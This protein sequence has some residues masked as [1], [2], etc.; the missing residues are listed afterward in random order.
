MSCWNRRRLR[1]SV[2]YADWERLLGEGTIVFVEVSGGGLCCPR[3]FQ[4]A[5][6]G[7]GFLNSSFERFELVLD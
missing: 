7:S 2:R 6:V 5:V 3:L 1:L 4:V